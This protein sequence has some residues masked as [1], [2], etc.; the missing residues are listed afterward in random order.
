M[1]NRGDQKIS[2]N[3]AVVASA[4]LSGFVSENL[5]VD[6]SESGGSLKDRNRESEYP[7]LESLI[8]AEQR[9]RFSALVTVAQWYHPFPFRTRK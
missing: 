2:I 7:N 6:A 4:V 5:Y 3:S 1:A 9:K 8:R